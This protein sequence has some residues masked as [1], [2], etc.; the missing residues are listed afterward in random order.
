MPR[1]SVVIPA[2]NRGQY[3]SCAIKSVLQ[4]TYR[5]I[6]IIVC[7]DG[8]TDNTAEVVKSIQIEADL[9]IILEVL[10]QNYG[11]SAARNRGI[12]LARGEY[13]AFLD[14]DDSWKPEKIE[15]QVT[16][17]DTNSDFIGVAC[18]VEFVNIYDSSKKIWEQNYEL[19]ESNEIFYMFYRCY[20]ITSSILVKKDAI[21]LAGLFDIRLK[22][23]EDRDLFWRLPRIGRIGFLKDPLV[24]YLK[25]DSNISKE[26]SN[27]TGEIYLPVVKKSVFYYK[28]KLTEN[29][30][31][32]ILSMAHLVAAY[33]SLAGNKKYLG[34]WYSTIA[35]AYRHNYIEAIKLIMSSVI[36]II[37]MKFKITLKNKK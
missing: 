6:E 30:M 17:L 31:R 20:V 29:E 21:I 15:K 9:P 3:I 27:V 10:P 37:R 8:S 26:M 24:N 2:F 11:V 33:D 22:I 14:S 13:I 16:F 12:F 1:V 32:K 34:I 35:I 18:G 7:D 23:S 4:Q 5:D 19:S 36:S 25:H 28:D